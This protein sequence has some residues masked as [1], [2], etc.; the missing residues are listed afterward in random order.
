MY[1]AHKY[2]ATWNPFQVIPNATI[3]SATKCYIFLFIIKTLSFTKHR[4]ITIS[5]SLTSQFDH[6]ILPNHQQVYIDFSE[7]DHVLPNL[8]ECDQRKRRRKAEEI[9]APTKT[10][11]I[12]RHLFTRDISILIIQSQSLSVNRFFSVYLLEKQ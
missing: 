3:Q 6:P 5:T 4:C 12:R 11:T 9:L 7:F 2:Q 1:S 10:Y 8:P